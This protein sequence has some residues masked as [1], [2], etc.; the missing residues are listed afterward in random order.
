MQTPKLVFAWNARG[1]RFASRRGGK[2]SI[3]PNRPRGVATA[4]KMHARALHANTSFGVR[5]NRACDLRTAVAI[6]CMIAWI[7]LPS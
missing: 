1:V 4:R 7:A 2:R 5:M 3:R 6:Y